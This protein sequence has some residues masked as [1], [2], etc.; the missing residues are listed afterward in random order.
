MKLSRAAGKLG[1][2]ALA[3]SSPLAVAGGDDWYF[4]GNI[5][6]S[7]T[8]FDSRRI[9]RDLQSSGF[10]LIG[11]H[12]N[13]R[14]TGFKLFG[15]YRLNRHFSLEAGA[16]DLGHFSYIASTVPAGSLRGEIEV[17]GVNFD[18]VGFLPLTEKWSA[19]GRAGVNYARA[20]VG[21]TST[22]AVNV[23]DPTHENDALNIKYGLGAQYDFNRSIA[24]RIEAERYRIDDVVGNGGD[25]DLIS[26]GFVVSFGGEPPAPIA[27]APPPPP[28]PAPPPPPVVVEAPPPTPVQTERYCSL[29]EFQ[30]EINQHEVRREEREKLAVIG[31]FLTKYPNTRAEIEGHTDD[32]G[33]DAKNQVLSQRR[34]DAVVA[35]LVRTFSI[36]PSR[37]AAVGYGESRPVADNATEEGKRQN[38]RIGAIVDCATDVEGLWVRPARTTMALE[39]EFD[40]NDAGIRP[41]YR[42]EL[43][44]L[45]EFLKANPRVTA[46]VEG[47]TGNLQTTPEQ[48]QEISQRRAQ[49]VVNHLV[50][51]LGIDRMR[52]SAQGFGHTR[53]SAYNSSAEGQQDNRRVNVIINY[54]R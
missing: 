38:R 39:I 6:E 49:N 53:R 52:L 31:N 27:V 9:E 21:L 32:V 43:R 36:A 8:E 45:A 14:D 10:D 47:H 13:D 17:Q 15:G 33:T 35:Y 23:I 37:L 54:P 5:G 7:N 19:F 28:P 42:N 30:F 20:E 48:A 50:D 44:G 41:E 26:I 1:L 40:A 46:A 18:L 3:I 11:M 2:A 51:N 12:E 34:A 25:I 29:L 4:G 16:F 24:M 22:G